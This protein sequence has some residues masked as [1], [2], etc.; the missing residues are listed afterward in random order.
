MPPSLSELYKNFATRATIVS[1]DSLA[2]IVGSFTKSFSMAMAFVIVGND[3][4]A[5]VV[6]GRLG[7]LFLR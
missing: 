6:V 5:I 2:V 1:N 7:G 4:L 3:S